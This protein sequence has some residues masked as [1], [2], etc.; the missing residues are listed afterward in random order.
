VARYLVVSHVRNM[1]TTMRN[2]Y[3]LREIE[4]APFTEEHRMLRRARMDAERMVDALIKSREIGLPT[5]LI[6]GALLPIFASAGRAS[7]LLQDAR[8]ATVFSLVGLGFGLAASWVI[9]R[10]AAMASRRIRL[11]TQAPARLLWDSVGWCG[12]PQKDG[13]RT[14]VLVAVSLT[15]AAWVII[16][17]L[18]GIAYAT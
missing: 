2:L 17:I 5:F 10:G 9:L 6:G 14:F 1:A 11:A 8:W 7:G 12:N 4:S 15:I 13:T 18:I 3:G 16:P